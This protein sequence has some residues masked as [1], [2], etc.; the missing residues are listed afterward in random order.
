[1]GNHKNNP[2]FDRCPCWHSLIEKQLRPGTKAAEGTYCEDR[3]RC[4]VSF[5]CLYFLRLFADIVYIDV[6][7]YCIYKYYIYIYYC[8][9]IFYESQLAG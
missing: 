6:D 7:R 2:T 8:I 1:M 3:G 9:D 5:C 4:V